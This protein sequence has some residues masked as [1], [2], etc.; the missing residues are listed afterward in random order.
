MKLVSIEKTTRIE[1]LLDKSAANIGFCNSGAET[2]QLGIC[3]S[4]VL[5]FGL[6][7][8]N[9]ALVLNFVISFSIG[10]W[11][12]ADEYKIPHHRKALFVV[13]HPR[14]TPCKPSTFRQ[15]TEDSQRFVKLKEVQADTQSQ[16]FCTTFNFTPT[17]QAHPPPYKWTE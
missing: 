13:R 5:L 9:L 15:N 8:I 4:I 14:R 12:W 17:H 2:T 3:N 10:L 11:L 1:Q 16:R 6:D 7:V